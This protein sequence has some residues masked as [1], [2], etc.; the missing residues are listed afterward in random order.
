[1]ARKVGEALVTM[2]SNQRVYLPRAK[3]AVGKLTPFR[4]GQGQSKRCFDIPPALRA[5]L[6]RSAEPVGRPDNKCG[7]HCGPDQVEFKFETSFFSILSK[8]PGASLY[9]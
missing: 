7:G 9:L 4:L 1:M 5:A 6:I 3:T 8:M 2:G